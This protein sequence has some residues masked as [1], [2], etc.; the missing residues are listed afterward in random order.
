MDSVDWLLREKRWSYNRAELERL[1]PNIFTSEFFS[2]LPLLG[3]RS[4][5][6]VRE[7][8]LDEK[9]PF[10]SFSGMKWYKLAIKKFNKH[11]R[12]GAE[13][14]ARTLHS[15][16]MI[17]EFWLERGQ[18]PTVLLNGSKKSRKLP[19]VR[20]PEA[21]TYKFPFLVMRSITGNSYVRADHL[22][23]DQR[24]EV[25]RAVNR[26]GR[27]IAVQEER[28]MRRFKQAGMRYPAPD[29]IPTNVI[30]SVNAEGE[31][32]EIWI[33]DQFSVPGGPTDEKA[34]QHGGLRRM[35]DRERWGL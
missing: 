4:E 2:A 34:L 20:V 5:G 32:K 11:P 21:L 14:Q 16:H 19:L 17:A 8:T 12:S 1:V 13:E 6:V 27:L 25:Y 29:F 33:I 22:P 18:W 35:S 24:Q 26:V 15:L 28:L 30:V 10:V 23:V 7:L 9:S 31:I 3:G